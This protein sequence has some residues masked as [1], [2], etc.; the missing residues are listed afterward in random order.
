MQGSGRYRVDERVD[1]SDGPGVSARPCADLFEVSGEALPGRRGTAV[2]G[3][4]DLRD[5]AAG[6]SFDDCVDRRG[7]AVERLVH[8]CQN[9]CSLLWI[10]GIGVRDQ[11]EDVLQIVGGE[12]LSQR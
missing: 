6:G 7:D 1:E 3:A 5:E 12:N 9:L 10:G 2:D 4:A 8:R 11:R